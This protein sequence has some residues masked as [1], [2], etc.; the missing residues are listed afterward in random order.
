[1]CVCVCV[2]VCVRVWIALALSLYIYIYIYI[3]IYTYIYLYI[4]YYASF[5][6]YVPHLLK[7]LDLS[8]H[9]DGVLGVE[10]KQLG[11]ETVGARRRSRASRLQRTKGVTGN[12]QGRL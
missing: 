6:S 7:Y 2:C 11:R 8:R 5:Y 10:L 12:R 4:Y 3:Y 1:M 9:R